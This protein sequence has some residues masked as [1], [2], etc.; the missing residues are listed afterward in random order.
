M[1]VVMSVEV[2]WGCGF[3]VIAGVL[4]DLSI[5]VH[6]DGVIGDWEYGMSV[7]HQTLWLEL[8]VDV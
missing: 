5:E 6:C 3:G 7:N 2:F 8:L 1:R 4:F